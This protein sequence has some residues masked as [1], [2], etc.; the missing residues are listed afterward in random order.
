[1]YPVQSDSK[2]Q[3]ELVPSGDLSLLRGEGEERVREEPWGN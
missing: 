1:M 3:G 2:L